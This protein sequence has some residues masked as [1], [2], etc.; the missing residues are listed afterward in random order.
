MQL[1]KKLIYSAIAASAALI[2]SIL[3]PIVPCRLAPAVPNPTY[4]WTLCSLNP[5]IQTYS[6]S[7]KEF[8]GYTSS[9]TD[10]YFIVLL[11]AFGIAMAFFHY[12]TRRKKDK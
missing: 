11:L 12:T 4:K 2:T 9:L 6:N 7:I 3:I 5:D 8:F 10:S 1:K